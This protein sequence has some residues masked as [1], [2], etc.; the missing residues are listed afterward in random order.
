MADAHDLTAAYALDALDPA[1]EQEYES[2]LAT[3]ERCRDELAALRDAAAALA[4]AAPAPVPPPA[5]RERVLER[6]RTERA[7]VIQ[8]R[9]RRRFT[10]ALAAAAAVAACL[11]IGLGVWA[12]SLSDRL[13]R[14]QDVV[15]IMAQGNRVPLQ[16]TDG[17]LFVTDSG[18]AVVVVSQLDPAPAGKTYELWVIQ[19]DN[20]EPAGLF[21]GGG[22]EVLKLT[23]R[24]PEG[25]TVAGTIE[26]DGGVD[27]PTT[28]PFFS[29]QA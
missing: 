20:A 23:R 18:D 26:D 3:C 21:E 11:A 19:G 7:P 27:A 29:A 16:G 4:Y 1:E 13:D 12:A 10:F 8:L 25:A 17:Q 28:K 6:A 24:V 14:Q 5:L 15:A 9:P 2:H 22:R